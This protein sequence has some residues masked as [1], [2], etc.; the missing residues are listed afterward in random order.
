MAEDRLT[1]MQ[2]DVVRAYRRVKGYSQE[3]V[4]TLLGV[5]RQ[6]YV[7]VE[8]GQ[9]PV[10][11]DDRR[12]LARSLGIPPSMLGV[13]GGAV[14][15]LPATDLV[16]A[17]WA[18]FYSGTAPGM[19]GLVPH[20][21]LWLD[22]QPRMS[23]PDSGVISQLYQAI[24]TSL[25]DA[26]M[27]AAALE[28]ANAG[29]VF[30]EHLSGPREPNADASSAYYRRSRVYAGMAES[31]RGERRGD[32]LGLAATDAAE[33]VA[34][35]P[36][37]RL[38]LRVVSLQNLAQLQAIAGA[39]PMAAIATVQQAFNL[40]GGNTRYV[41]DATNITLSRSGLYHAAARVYIELARVAD[42]RGYLESAED[43][44]A[45]AI[46]ALSAVEH[47]WNVDMHI[48]HM[49]IAARQGNMRDAADIAPQIASALDIHQSRRLGSRA[50]EV[51]SR[52]HVPRANKAARE[53]L[54]DAAAQIK[55]MITSAGVV[56]V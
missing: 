5:A 39:G 19:L 25:R 4:A 49:E 56:A 15:P 34:R 16:R 31:A 44:I 33:A 12:L 3:Y 9:A 11:N 41:R 8:Q 6:T 51:I 2:A 23:G 43:H 36:G 10:G 42:G 47:R 50:L 46:G 48:T 40:A 24:T 17:L 13:S 7:A 26:R 29:V 55:R 14:V 1:S 32:L 20:A 37:D 30:A 54:N 45:D 18:Q 52:V 27:Y 28:T 53:N 35:S 38:A 21:Q 22:E